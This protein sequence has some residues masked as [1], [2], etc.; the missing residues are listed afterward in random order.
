MGI[1]NSTCAAA[2]MHA[3]TGADAAE[4]SRGTG[5]DAATVERKRD[6]IA[7]A[8]ARHGLHAIGDAASRAR[9]ALRD[10]GGVEV[11]MMAGAMLGAAA[12]RRVFIVDGFIATAAYAA[13]V[14]IEPALQGYGV[15]ARVS[16]EA[17]HAR[18]LQTLGAQPL[19]NLGLRLGEG[20]A[21][22]P[23][24]PLLR[25]ACAMLNGMA[26]FDSA[27]VSGRSAS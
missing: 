23:A 25:A 20:S 7:A 2:L 12:T 27:G 13:T 15:F 26:T 4:C 17:P 6:V 8:V 5:A 19:F 1:G 18:W 24:V 9:A 10:V 21:A 3:L 16:A 22:A 14:A 11:S